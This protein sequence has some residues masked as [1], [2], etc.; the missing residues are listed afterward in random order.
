[1]PQFNFIITDSCRHY[2][3]EKLKGLYADSFIGLRLRRVD[4]TCA[5]IVEMALMGRKSVGNHGY[6][7][8]ISWDTIDDVESAI[9]KE[10]DAIK[11]DSIGWKNVAKEAKKYFDVGT[12]WL[13]T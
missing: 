13:E 10:Y 9:L 8:T 4:G 3:K 7:F 11:S 12:Y 1:M 2:T 5:S 6:P